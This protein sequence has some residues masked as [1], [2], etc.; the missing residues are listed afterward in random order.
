MSMPQIPENCH[1]PEIDQAII[2]LLESIAL[3]EISLSHILN[4]EAERIQAFV[5][6]N[7]EFPTSPS[8]IEILHF[9]K[10]TSSL[11]DTIIMKEWILYKK[12]L[13]TLEVF[14]KIKF[15]KKETDNYESKD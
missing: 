12:L 11:L 5:G 2:D 7:Q 6:K 13:A 8:N 9:N 10:S 14:G 4:A 3:E 15:Y 1:R